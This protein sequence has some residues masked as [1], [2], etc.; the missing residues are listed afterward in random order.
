MTTALKSKAKYFDY[1]PK[2][3]SKLEHF[4]GI[5][6][7]VDAINTYR[8]TVNQIPNEVA[9][10]T[11]RYSEVAARKIASNVGIDQQSM[12]YVDVLREPRVR[13]NIT[14]TIADLF[15]KLRKYGNVAAH[16]NGIIPVSEAV[17]SLVTLDTLLRVFARNLSGDKSLNPKEEIT[18]EMFVITYN[19][20]DRKLIYI[21]S[22]KD[23]DGTW[24]MYQGLE[25][26]GDASVPE[27]YEAD[28]TPNSEYLREYASRRIKQYMTTAGVPF[29]LHWA[30]LAVNKKNQF[31]RDHDVH[32]VL[33]RS[34][35]NPQTIGEDDTGKPNEWFS[36][37]VD[38]AKKAIQA[39]KDG[40]GSLDS[41]KDDF[42]EFKINFRPEQKDAIEQTKTVFKTKDEMLW[43]AKM[44]FGKTLSSLQVIKESQ[45]KKVLIMTH[46]P[47]V[48]DGWFTDFKKIFT[49]G[50]YIYGSKQDGEKIQNLV[51]T[52]KPFIYFASI[53]DLR[54]SEWAGGKAGDKNYEFLAID[55]DFIIIDEAHEGN[56]T[57]L[58]NNVKAKLR[59]EHTKVLELSGTP[60][61][62][63]D[64]YDED[65][66]FTWDYTMEQEAKE[67][68]SVEHPNEPNPYEGLPKVSM[69]TFEIPNKFDYFDENKAFN[70]REFFR[71]K[72]DDETKLLHE[73]DVRKFL[74]YITTNDE[75]TNFPFSKPEFRENLR[76]TL[77][78]MPGVK[79]AN[80]FERV[81]ET[82][83]IF[84]DYNIANVVKTG[85]SEHASDSD[86]ELVRKAIGNPAKSKTITLTVRK[87]T[88]GVN[89]PEWTGV[90]F[91]S[92]TESPTSYLQAAFRAQ[93]PFNH[94]ELGI[95]KNCYIFDFAPDRAL[96]IMS[97][98]VGL[99]SKKG[100]VN[101]SEQKKKLERM[102]NFLPILGK[103]GNVMKEFSVD[104]MLTAL[105]K[106]YAEKAVRT[107]FEDSSL[108]NDNL[109]NLDQ[110]DLTKFEDLKKIVGSSKPTKV[111][112][113]IVSDNGMSEEEYE[114]ASRAEKKPKRQ[115][116]KEEQEAI[117][118]AKRLREQRNKMISILRGVSIR[119]PMMIYGMDIDIKDDVTIEMFLNLVDEASWN[120]F[121]PEGLSKGRFREFIEYYDADVF[122]EAGRIIR[123][124]AKSYDE[125]DVIERTRK[126]GELFST[127]KNPDKETVLTPWRVVNM[128]LGNTI[129]GLSFFDEE[130]QNSTEN[131]QP[132]VRWRKTD[133]TDD[134]FKENRKILEINSK[135]GLYPLYA[136]TSMYYVQLL[137]QSDI[138]A[139]R[140]DSE[141]IWEKVLSEQIFV[142]SKTPMAKTITK[143]TLIGYNAWKVNVEY[144]SELVTSMKR[145]INDG[146]TNLKG[147]YKNV[148]FDVI[149]G[150]PPYQEKDGGSGASATPLYNLFVETSVKLS[151]RYVSMIT[152]S[153]WFAGGKG[154]DKYRDF[155]LNSSSLKVMVDIVNGK[156]IFP[157]TSIGGGVSY[158][159]WDKKYNGLTQYTNQH[160]GVSNTQERKMNEFPVFVRYNEAI[161]AIHKIGEHA[162]VGDFVISRNPFGLP[163]KIR[164]EEVQDSRNSIKVISSGGVGFVPLEDITK[165]QDMVG[166]Y[167][168]ISSSLTS[169]H[170]GEPNKNGM[171][172]VISTNRVIKPNEV[173]T[174][175]YL[176]LFSAD[177]ETE[178]INYLKYLRTRFYR[179][180]LLQAVT[181]IHLSKDKFMFIPVQDFTSG[182]DINWNVGIEEV[183]MQLFKKYS[184]DASEILFIDQTIVPILHEEYY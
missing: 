182:S 139:G 149:I 91:L 121:M 66:I 45:Y 39:V 160:D 63:F 50:S 68:W 25:K 24:K 103:Q 120:E 112:D 79:E 4:L 29:V 115:R 114:K 178:A 98:S 84:K 130:Y 107:G 87:L 81:L 37:T 137:K 134:I 61:N 59:K 32:E 138:N 71:V 133:C 170:A 7:L 169:E 33:K 52:E 147:V 46:R 43:N 128:H 174:D 184:F 142:I 72:E 177:T 73:G 126:I 10:G 167:K 157:N 6:N 5:P 58:A 127:F 94:A 88:T 159:L 183:D 3:G 38:V 166:K 95:K 31:F 35:Y 27:N 80:A 123:R 28:F 117:D 140:V 49:D 151:E 53:Q 20:F 172:K 30:Q 180:L 143:R 90:F 156:E 40:K 171:F 118:R 168:V 1:L 144:S 44:R 129:G 13:N 75:K 62:L 8:V 92:N 105:K 70:F 165:G 109:L 104:R 85:D 15:H 152:P 122:V 124:R 67:K 158:F 148:K 23:A 64:K 17:E 56:E 2:Y 22:A 86:L 83:P 164:G 145:S 26:I 69:F 82:H 102:L 18:D 78:L 141:A 150:N 132:I 108:Y 111:K 97:G 106:A 125:L 163:T 12:K 60:F 9:I 34:G 119:I 99:T 116:T 77:W 16:E 21:Q 14:P 76:H 41:E 74:D 136:A 155:M 154:L 19:T 131:G 11:R 57:E 93:T 161:S 55:W 162:S 51:D 48:S 173:V 89:V 146:L 65:N 135:T 113:F 36:V 181:S 54:G 175:S 153:K 96:K 101:S 42:D 47:V 100:K 176:V 179:F 110:A